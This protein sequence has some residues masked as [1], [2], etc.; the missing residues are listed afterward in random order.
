M[1]F[2]SIPRNRSRTGHPEIHLEKHRLLQEV[3]GTQ[4]DQGPL[5]AAALVVRTGPGDFRSDHERRGRKQSSTPANGRQLHAGIE[6]H[7]C[8]QH[9]ERP[10]VEGG[11]G[12]NCGR[13]AG[14]NPPKYDHVFASWTANR[15]E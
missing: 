8:E 12:A 1:A 11:R 10:V 3:P 9:T 4:R 15:V 14:R 2:Q 7:R 13:C 6:R 5:H